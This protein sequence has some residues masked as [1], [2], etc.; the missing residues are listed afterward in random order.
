MT[1]PTVFATGLQ[2][3]ANDFAEAPGLLTGAVKNVLA[4]VTIP[5]TTA[6]NTL[7]GLVP[8]NAGAVFS[9]GSVFSCTDIDTATGTTLDVG[10]CY[11][12]TVE[13]TDVVDLFIDGSTISQGGG[14][15]AFSDIT[16][17]TYVATGKGYV[18]AKI[19]G[20]A[21]SAAG[22]MKLNGL[23]SYNV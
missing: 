18:T 8:V 22:T 21:A 7:I 23:V 19:L 17:M 4:E 12:D 13:G 1:L 2:G 15:A 14:T 10:I 16:G 3:N 6:E 20:A 5:D 11:A 9:Y